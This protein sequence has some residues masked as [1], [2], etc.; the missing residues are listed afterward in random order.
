MSR[1]LPPPWPRM[2]ARIKVREP[3]SRKLQDRKI[4]ISKKNV[5][6]HKSTTENSNVEKIHYVQGHSSLQTPPPGT[7]CHG[8]SELEEATRR[9][10]GRPAHRHGGAFYPTLPRRVPARAEPP[11]CSGACWEQ[12]AHMHPDCRREDR[13]R[14]E[15]SSRCLRTV[16]LTP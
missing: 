3:H 8:D 13:N 16:R 9:P 5:F 1:Q 14:R 6:L 4:F 12:G 7:E 15:L 11:R 2:T 10:T